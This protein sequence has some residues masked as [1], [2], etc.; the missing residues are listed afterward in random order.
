MSISLPADNQ[1]T[2]ATESLLIRRISQRDQNALSELYEL[3]VSRVYGLAMRVLRN[4]SDAEEVV[5]DVY[6]QIWDKA[7]SFEISRGSVAAWMNTM[8]WSRAMDRLRK[9]KRDFMKDALHPEDL[10][11]TYTE[12]EGLSIEQMAESWSSAKT[13]QAAFQELSEIQ[14]RVL[15]LAYTDDLSHQDIANT[16]SLPLGTVKSHVKRGLSALR[17]VLIVQE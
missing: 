1:N 7:Q 16:L 9:S 5:S 10:V 6:L 8:A 3:T 11:A 4:T 15:R 12:C 13:I 2:G 17:S 14:Q